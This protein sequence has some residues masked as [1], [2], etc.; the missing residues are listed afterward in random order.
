MHSI[1]RRHL[2]KHVEE[3]KAGNDAVAVKKLK[4]ES[5]K[6]DIRLK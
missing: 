6:K 2:E 1:C 3:S 4:N 5:T